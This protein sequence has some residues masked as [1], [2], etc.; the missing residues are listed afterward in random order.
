MSKDQC[1]STVGK[2]PVVKPRTAT[3]AEV[4]VTGRA[5]WRSAEDLADTP[6]FRDWMER[7]FPDGASELLDSSRRTFVKLMGAS[8]ALA[9][10]ATM[11][12]C[13]RPEQKIMAYSRDVPEEIIPG[14]PLYF[15]T[16]VH[17]PGGAVE[18]V[19]VETHEGRPVKIE[20]NPL[21]PTN[22]GKSSHWAQSCILGMYDPDR[23]KDPVLVPEGEKTPRSWD[24]V[25][26]WSKQH[27]AKFAGNDGEGLA[28][29]VDKKRSPSRLAVKALVTTR[30]PKATWVAYDPIQS[31]TSLD[32]TRAAFGKPMR[33]VLH[34]DKA[35][36]VVCFDRDFVGDD[37]DRVRNMRGFA[38]MRR[39]LDT[40][41]PM[42]RI[43]SF[44]SSFSMTGAKA[45]H[46]WA[47]PPSAVAAFAAALV[48]EI[49]TQKAGSI[50]A[51]ALTAAGGV[52]SVNVAG[53]G[54]EVIREIAKDLLSAGTGKS[55]VLAGPTQPAAVHAMCIA[56]NEALGN[57]GSTVVYRGVSAD[58]AMGLS[59][60]ASLASA[61]NAG[62]VDTLV[63]VGANPVYDTPASMDFAGAFA[64]VPHRITASVGNNET[65]EA[66]TWRLPLAHDL[67]SWGDTEAVDGTLAPI[68]PMIA[69]LFGAKSDLEV[70]LI[71]A[72]EATTDGY[73]FVRDVWKGRLG[74]GFEK[75]WRRALHDGVFAGAEAKP[76]SVKADGA[77]TAALMGGVTAELPRPEKMDVVFAVGMPGDGRFANTGWLQELPDPVTKIV[78]D[79]V[80]LIS[81]ATTAKYDV[82]RELPTEQYRR[83]RMIT[84]SVDG[85]TVAI[86]AWEQPGIPDNTVVVQLGYGRKNC[87]LVGDG[88]G[89]NVFGLSGNGATSSNRRVASGT[90][91]RAN[92][93]ERWR[94]ISTTQMHGTMDG[95]AIVREVDLPAWKKFGDDPFGDVSAERKARMLVDSYGNERHLNFGERLGELAHSPANVS[96][97]P[98]PQRG[99]RELGEPAKGAKNAYGQTP[100][101]AHG[102]QWGMSIDLTTC[103]GCSACTVACQAENNIP[104]VGKI[105]VNKG[106]EM[107]WIRVDRYFSGPTSGGVDPEGVMFQPVACVHCENAPCETVCPVNATVHGPEGINYMVY[108]RCIGTRYCANNCPYKVRRFNYFQWGTK[109]YQ[110]GYIGQEALKDVG[111]EGPTNHNW[112]PARLRE[113]LNEVQ[114]LQKNP[115]VTVRMRGV[116]EKCS[117]CIQRINEA[118]IE[119]KLRNMK[120]IPDGFVQTACQQSCPT[121]AI[122]FG[123]IHDPESRV[124][125]L[126]EH[127]RSYLL[128]GFL[129]TR[130]RTTYMTGIRNP[131]P[132]LA[133]AHRRGA[134]DHPFDH[135]GG[136][137]EGA[138][139]GGH[140][141]LGYDPSK[142]FNDRGY[143]MSLAVLGG[144]A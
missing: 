103:V 30:Y 41:G 110:G 84:L 29:L 62:K 100:D 83:A 58:E 90:I 117:Y 61:M 25:K 116:M 32:A 95:R 38:A 64:K 76:E 92:G 23:L 130:P 111:L 14:K 9:G 120:D 21:H 115:D 99:G 27:F 137:S 36:V 85:Q 60:L 122:V 91:E 66:S 20:G 98:N 81:P 71:A 126:R 15:A 86:P 12:G 121:D 138:E 45:D 132:A 24:D 47:V 42:S 59:A 88:V 51:A 112:I 102:P 77:K 87:G 8:L 19:L 39:V 124:A 43:Y 78:W 69:P 107:H 97:Y 143:K 52:A 49:G 94:E 134:W 140:A 113:E 89:V 56:I 82:G 75:K 63:T 114:K 73:G 93:E 72:G 17:L 141:L 68:Q 34:L 26:A 4:G 50:S 33:E 136:G 3:N 106:R 105:E 48:K 144:R 11:P 28:F 35:A 139:G 128:L 118:R 125:K 127:Q 65:I 67:E 131:N 2:L 79:N 70:L 129:N 5:Y 54:A 6:E 13:R 142:S 53:V 96:A 57:I 37:A 1:H 10:A 74:D 18:G 119:V 22:N 40:K 55:V 104:I 101:F 44:E 108:N 133:G 16:S 80:A 31:E 135:H 46:R 7:E 123:D 109:R